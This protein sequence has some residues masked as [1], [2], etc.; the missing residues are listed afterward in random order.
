MKLREWLWRLLPDQCEVSDCCRKGVR[1]N[2]NIIYPFEDDEMLKEFYII[3]CD[4]CNS[5]WVRG[6]VMNVTGT[7]PRMLANPKKIVDFKTRRKQRRQK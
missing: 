1:G 2:E 4:Y 7:L 5:K 6:E 3:M